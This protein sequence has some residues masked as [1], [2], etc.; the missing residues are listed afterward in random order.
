LFLRRRIWPLLCALVII[1]PACG[2]GND[3]ELG[4]YNLPIIN[5]APDSTH[6][7]V[8]AITFGNYMCS[9]TLISSDVIL[10]AGHCASGYGAS[11]FRVYFGSNIQSA[12][13]RTVSEVKVHPGYDSVNIVNDVA[14]LRLAS[15][16]PAGIRPIPYLP[17]SMGI[18]QADIDNPI[19]FVGFGQTET[20]STGVRMS[21]TS[22]L[23]WICTSSGG[24]TIGPG[25]HASQNT[26]CEDQAPGGT[27]HGDSGGPAFVTRAGQEY[28]A[29]I[30][31][32]GDQNCL[33]F[34]CSTKVDEFETFIADFV[35]GVLGSTCIDSSTCLSGNCIDGVC[36]ESTCVG[37]CM[38]C[39]VAGN[40]GRCVPA[41]NGTPCP[42]GN[43]CNGEEVCLMQECVSGEP[44]NCDDDNPCT[45]DNCTPAS[46]CSND[47]VADGA[48]CPDADLC[49]GDESCQSGICRAGSALDC[50]DHNPCTQD[51]CSATIGCE[52]LPLEDGISCGGGVC[53]PST[54]R[55]G[56]CEPDD[57]S[58]C[59]DGDPCTSN[60]CD[61]DFGC[62]YEQYPD[63]HE[64]GGCRMCLAGT[65]VEDEACIVSGGC[66]SSGGF[67]GGM[68]LLWLALLMPGVK[69]RHTARRA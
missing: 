58:V 28:V 52:N 62:V 4:V 53:G 5:G 64:C 42:D 24:C 46:G 50:D 20:Y 15:P 6:E 26:I 39:N 56:A 60:S 45:I 16:P 17:H 44:L 35:G 11:A 57:A 61:P 29:G 66:S 36:C 21:I 10:T 25:Y 13:S 1:L 2:P 18:V 41:P 49:N 67:P 69:R 7:A 40:L 43:A 22:D 38:S 68:I 33:Y 37:T 14:M 32:Y 55:A 31:S 8:V 27:C 19:E 9:G 34:G 59:D 63:G 12:T 23:D 47:A 54:C 30:T 3:V 51:A 65:C 48:A